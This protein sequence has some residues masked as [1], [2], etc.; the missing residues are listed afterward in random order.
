MI[1]PVH[2]AHKVIQAFE[3]A[4]GAEGRG[5]ATDL[6]C[7]ILRGCFYGNGCACDGA[8]IERYGKR[9]GRLFLRPVRDRELR[10][11][12]GKER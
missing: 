8:F 6:E 12:L 4:W 1:G 5:V 10:R 2:D 7:A 11:R 9:L 3:R